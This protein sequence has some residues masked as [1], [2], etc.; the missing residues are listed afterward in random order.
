MKGLKAKVDKPVEQV[1][2]TSP[3]VQNKNTSKKEVKKPKKPKK[4]VYEYIERKDGVNYLLEDTV[5]KFSS[6]DT[7]VKELDGE[8]L[9]Q[10]HKKENVE[11]RIE[12]MKLRIQLAEKEKRDIETAVFHFKTEK[13][14]AGLLKAEYVTKVGRELGNI[15]NFGYDP[16]T[17]EVKV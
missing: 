4:P 12:N 1:A 6:F 13:K 14:K 8:I 15:K 5:N 16:D 17:L 11:L 9:K 2:K 7:Q 3:K 10:E